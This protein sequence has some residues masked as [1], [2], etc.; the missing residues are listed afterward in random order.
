[1][2]PYIR[3]TRI[4][5]EEPHH[6]HLVWEVCNGNQKWNFDYYDNADSLIK[7]SEKLEVFP[8]HISDVFLWELGSEY[9]EDRWG[10][11][12][13][14]RT[15]VWNS[16]GHCAIQI[17]FNNNKILPYL[18]IAEFCIKVDAAE[19]N[20]LGRLFRGFSELN[21]ELLVWGGENEGLYTSE[22]EI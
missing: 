8:I 14:F 17:R 6:I 18:E 10:Y 5:Y 7:F 19:I 9:P 4:P 12:F 22:H 13:R 16:V 1:M 3:I 11:Y 15:F 21:H 20:R 2:S